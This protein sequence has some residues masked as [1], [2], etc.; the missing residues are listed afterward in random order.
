[1]DYLYKYAYKTSEELRKKE[2]AKKTIKSGGFVF[3]KLKILTELNGIL[4]EQIQNSLTNCGFLY[5]DNN[6]IILE[7][8]D[9]ILTYDI[10][11]EKRNIYKEFVNILKKQNDKKLTNNSLT[12]IF[13]ILK[14]ANIQG[15]IITENDLNTAQK[16]YIV[17][18]N[19][20]KDDVTNP[21]SIYFDFNFI[22]KD[23]S[24][25]DIYELLNS[26]FL[27]YQLEDFERAFELIEK[28]ILQCL[29][30][31]N[32]T[33]L[34]I[35]MFNKNVLL[36]KLKYGFNQNG[37]KYKDIDEYNLEEKFSELPKDLKKV[38]KPI[39]YFL[40]ED[41]LYK[42]AYKTSEELRK[43]EDAKKTIK[44]GGFV[45]SSNI[46]E[47]SSKH[48]NL[49]SFVIRNGIMIEEYNVFRIINR[50]FLNISIIRQIQQEKT[51]FNKT[52]LFSALKYLSNKEL[53]HLLVEFYKY[54]S[55]L[56]GK[57]EI[58]NSNKEWLISKVLINIVDKY[59]E[60]KSAFNKFEQYLENLILLL[61]LTKLTDDEINEILNIFN[62][63]IDKAKNTIGI[64]QSINLFLG[65]QYNLYNTAI[66]E[67]SL[68]NLIKTIINKFVH[69]QYNGHDFHA[70][71]R[72]EIS[73]LYGYAREN[74]A[75]FKEESLIDKLISSSK[76]L[77]IDEQLNISES[78]L[79]SIY[80]IASEQIKAKLKEFV[81]SIKSS[82][83]KEKHDY[84]IFEL[85]LI[86]RD[87]KQ[88]NKNTIKELSV[89]FEQFK[90][91]RTF[92]SVWYTLDSQ[93]DYLIKEKKLIQLEPI[94]KMIKVLIDNY[95]KSERLSIL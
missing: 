92:S 18:E 15:V 16:Q 32:Y 24:R 73:N 3:N 33:I 47:S 60:S 79:L 41:Y 17:I 83:T 81:L 35:S 6:K 63:I 76:E 94:S 59:I 84:L 93:I 25:N 23:K 53:K 77:S 22:Q 80:D 75:I 46:T 52:E 42:Y 55:D 71:T 86:I 62:T 1:E 88:L 48:N 70:I 67:D 28:T 31:K 82:K 8:Y 90:D 11:K 7:F 5:D 51:T 61:S 64:Y 66:N 50:Y 65:N 21:K 9:K 29:K 27:L 44:S 19:Y 26:S 2:D 54:D 4:L 72:N 56:K 12:S 13:E 37:D 58:S 30:Q 78:L 34:F 57:F 49:I 40:N 87:F 68:L 43:K 14:K 36:R 20:L 89:Y 10:N 74:N 38:V 69:K 39:Y 95:K 85:T 91:S 45:F